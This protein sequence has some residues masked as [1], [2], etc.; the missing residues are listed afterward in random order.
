[1]LGA[2]WAVIAAFL[3][4]IVG[5]LLWPIRSLLRRIRRRK[6]SAAESASEGF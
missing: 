3:L 5:I 6:Q 2:L 4:A 1:M